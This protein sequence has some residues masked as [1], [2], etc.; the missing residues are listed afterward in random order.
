MIMGP[1]STVDGDYG[2]KTTAVVRR[3]QA[4]HRLAEDGIVGNQTGPVLIVE[5]LKGSTGDAVRAVQSL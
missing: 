1:N 4:D 5:V 3:F 2:P